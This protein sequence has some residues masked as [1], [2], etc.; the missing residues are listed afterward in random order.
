M[1]AMDFA[2]VSELSPMGTAAAHLGR[3][4]RSFYLALRTMETN[5]SGYSGGSAS[6]HRSVTA[7][8]VVL[9]KP[10]APYEGE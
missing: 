7:V 9:T 1:L 3:T 6:V 2:S 10:R 5:P 8:G 4:L